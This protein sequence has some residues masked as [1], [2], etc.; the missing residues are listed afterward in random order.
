MAYV[1]KHTRLDKNEP[2][3]IGVGTKED[4]FNRAYQKISRN[5]YWKVIVKKT[6]YIVE[7]IFETDDVD[8]VF[9]KEIEYIA[10]Y[11][12]KDLGLGTLCNLTNGGTGGKTV[13][14]TDELR[15]KHS[16]G[17]KGEKNYWYGK[18]LT[19]EHK[20]KM[21]K[22]KLGKKC[23]HTNSHRESIVKNRMIPYILQYDL[24]NNL[25]KQWYNLEECVS[26]GFSKGNISMCCSGKRP[27]HKGFI[28]RKGE[29]HT[30]Y[31]YS[32][33]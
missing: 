24:E 17:N 7:I 31:K 13:E 2:F 14:M 18:K 12:R 9:Q 20:E 16:D 4:N 21:S 25:I 3:Y 32:I 22:A 8:L 29:L 6:E 19:E 28:W 26:F 23:N 15:K 5:K 10:F 11:G 1:Y 30:H 27:S 33:T